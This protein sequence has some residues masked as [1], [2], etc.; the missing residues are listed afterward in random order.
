MSKVR[1]KF[2]YLKVCEKSILTALTFIL[3]LTEQKNK[4]IFVVAHP[5]LQ[6][7]KQDNLEA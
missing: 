3:S 4:K 7:Y 2:F 5:L 6:H 1:V